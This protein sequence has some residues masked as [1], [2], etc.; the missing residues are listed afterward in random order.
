M[1]VKKSTDIGLQ[2]L[3]AVKEGGKLFRGQV[4]KH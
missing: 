1:M 2:F 4:N 3:V